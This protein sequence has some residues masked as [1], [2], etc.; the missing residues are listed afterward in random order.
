[1]P[2]KTMSPSQFE[3][4]RATRAIHDRW[5][6]DERQRRRQMAVSRQRQLLGKLI[7]QAALPVSS[8]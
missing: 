4:D 6:P 8:R 1:M 7:L 2:T 5:S 3:I